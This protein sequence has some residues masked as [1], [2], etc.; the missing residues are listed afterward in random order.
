MK[1]THAAVCVLILSGI[2]THYAS[3]GCT[4]WG[5]DCS[6]TTTPPPAGSTTCCKSPGYGA[7]SKYVDMGTGAKLYSQGSDECGHTATVIQGGNGLVCGTVVSY[8]D[9]GGTTAIAPCTGS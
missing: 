3:G 1:L 9:C 2:G 8:N 7:P 6:F 5:A 4:G